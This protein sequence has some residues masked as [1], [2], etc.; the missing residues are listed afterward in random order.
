MKKITEKM[1]SES[2]QLKD[3]ESSRIEINNKKKNFTKNTVK[4]KGLFKKKT[5]K[6]IKVDESLN[7]YQK[8]QK[9]ESEKES[10]KE[11]YLS[12]DKLYSDVSKTNDQKKITVKTIKVNKIPINSLEMQKLSKIKN[13]NKDKP[14]EYYIKNGLI[15][16]SEIKKNLLNRKKKKSA[17]QPFSHIPYYLNPNLDQNESQNLYYIQR[18]KSFTVNSKSKLKSF[19]NLDFVCKIL[20]LII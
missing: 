2:N 7:Q 13:E 9:N 19:S 17:R 15:S 10:K 14:A 12:Y 20:F 8:D 6:K 3:S 5:K 4:F 16:S 11:L 1:N 18:R